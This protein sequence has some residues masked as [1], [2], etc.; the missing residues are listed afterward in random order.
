MSGKISFGLP[1]SKTI[2]KIEY[3]EA[4]GLSKF[5]SF[6]RLPVDLLWNTGYVF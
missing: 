4:Y 5:S 2:E 6:D 1:F 3:G